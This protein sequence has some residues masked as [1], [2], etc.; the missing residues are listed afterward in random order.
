MQTTHFT[1]AHEVTVQAGD[2]ALG[3]SLVLPEHAEGLVAF[4]HGSGSSR[5]S[6]RNRYVADVL[7]QAGLG[8]LLVDLLTGDEDALDQRTRELR[9]DIELLSGRMTGILDWVGTQSSL[10]GLPVGLF[11]ASTGAAAALN[12]AAARPAQVC[13]LVSRGGRPDLAPEALPR[14]SCPTLLIVGGNDR[15]VIDLNERAASQLE[16]LHELYIVPGASHL[17]EETGA[18]EQVAKRARGWFLR[19]LCGHGQ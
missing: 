16:A 3:G 2:A 8:T 11:G 14:V 10:Q 9:F 1:T 19:Y 12:A 6:S 7:N 4:A 13:A 17:F 15:T 18:L 5:F